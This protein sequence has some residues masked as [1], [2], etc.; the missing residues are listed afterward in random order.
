MNIE[1]E[2]GEW[3]DKGP[4]KDGKPRRWRPFE[5]IM[6]G[7]RSRLI[8]QERTLQHPSVD[9]QLPVCTSDR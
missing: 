3:L 5:T 2:S 9:T 6:L 4:P 7:D 1:N 8:T